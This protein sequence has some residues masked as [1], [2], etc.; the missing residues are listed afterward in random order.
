MNSIIVDS[1]QAIQVRYDHRDQIKI[2]IDRVTSS[3][4][5]NKKWQKSIYKPE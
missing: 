5:D 3:D 1:G 2:T 4:L